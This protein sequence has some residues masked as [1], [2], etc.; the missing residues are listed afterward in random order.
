MYCIIAKLNR[1]STLHNSL[2]EKRWVH[3]RHQMCL[4]L[5]TSPTAGRKQAALIPFH[6]CPLSQNN[7]SQLA[8]KF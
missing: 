8:G 3:N 5:V 6:L 1:I 2:G 7:I 4:R